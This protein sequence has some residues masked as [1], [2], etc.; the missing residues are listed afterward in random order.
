MNNSFH[1]VQYGFSLLAICFSLFSCQENSN[2][3]PTLLIFSKTEGWHHESIPEGNKALIALGQENGFKVDTTTNSNY[4]QS[5]SL[6]KYSTVIFLSTT[7]DVLNPDQQQAFKS[8]IQ[9]GGG[10]VG[11]HGAADTEHGWNWYGELVG[12]YFKSHPDQQE[13]VLNVMN[14]K[15]PSTQHLPQQWV[16]FDEWY[17]FKNLSNDVNVLIT[18]DEESYTGGENGSDH[19]MAWFHEYDGGKAFYTGLGHTNEAFSNPAF[20]QHVLGGIK[21]TSGKR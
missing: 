11:I 4:F 12:G 14:V 9:S 21:Y 18:I 1:R 8:Y 17:N 6:K 20:L 16:R 13:A 7:G 15:H 5:D 19:P 3:E 2:P 10:F